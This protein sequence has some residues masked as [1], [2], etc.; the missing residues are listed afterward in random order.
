MIITSQGAKL[1]RRKHPG[2]VIRTTE[3]HGLRTRIERRN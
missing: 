1:K 2:T 3:K